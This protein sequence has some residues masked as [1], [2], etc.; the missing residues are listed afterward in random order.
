MFLKD[1]TECLV[2]SELRAPISTPYRSPT[3]P[4]YFSDLTA[5][6]YPP[7]GC[8]QRMLLFSLWS[9]NT[10]KHRPPYRPDTHTGRSL[11]LQFSPLSVHI[12]NFSYFRR[13]LCLKS[14]SPWGALGHVCPFSYPT[15]FSLL[16]DLVS[17]SSTERKLHMVGTRCFVLWQIAST[18]I[19]HQLKKPTWMN[20]W[21]N[22]ILS[23]PL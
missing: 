4:C 5:D 21:T 18:N 15:P 16:F 2:K 19:R 6:L 8:L 14:F 20:K 1:I 22:E 12:S 23:F 17:W 7:P 11:C 10:S 3:S 13:S 9:L